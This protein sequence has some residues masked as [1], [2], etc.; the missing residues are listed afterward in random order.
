MVGA[1]VLCPYAD[2][3]PDDLE[4]VANALNAAARVAIEGG[5]D[6]LRAGIENPNS[7]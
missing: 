4:S 6:V 3:F 2:L 5:A 1:R 7:E